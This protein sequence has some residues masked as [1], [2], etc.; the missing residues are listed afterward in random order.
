MPYFGVE[1]S[2]EG[3]EDMGEWHSPRIGYDGEDPHIGDN[4]CNTTTCFENSLLLRWECSSSFHE[5]KYSED[6][7]S[8]DYF[9]KMDEENSIEDHILKHL[10]EIDGKVIIGALHHEMMAMLGP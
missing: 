6:M 2:F 10:E 1:S 3:G 7:D 8:L 5:R 4:C 9:Q